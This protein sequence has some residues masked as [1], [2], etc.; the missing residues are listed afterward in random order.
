M[1]ITREVITAKSRKLIANWSLQQEVPCILC[2]REIWDEVFF[3]KNFVPWAKTPA[4]HQTIFEWW[5][6]KMISNEIT[7]E[8]DKEI[9]EVLIENN[10]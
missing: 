6:S 9:L 1:K 3:I 5:M 10:T 8:I 4:T 7:R 2:G